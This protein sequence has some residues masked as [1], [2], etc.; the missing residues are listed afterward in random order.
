MAPVPSYSSLRVIIPVYRMDTIFSHPVWSLSVALEALLLIRA[1]RTGLLR[2]F[3]LFYSYIL[4]VLVVDLISTPVYMH[5]PSVYGSF[6]WST[7]LLVAIISYGVLIEIYNQSL[8][9]YD[10]VARFFKVLL[11]IIFCVASTRVAITSL[12][13]SGKGFARAVA[14]LEGDVRQIQVLLLCCLLI[15]FVYYK[16]SIARNLRGLIL[17]Y[18]LFLSTDSISSAFIAHPANGLAPLMRK[19]EPAFYALS[20]VIWVTSL[21]VSHTESNSERSRELEQDYEY[22]ASATRTMLLRA[23]T[24][25]VRASRL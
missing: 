4:C 16:V 13:D 19:V 25:L 1:A 2:N 21:W 8:Q 22:F 17:G 7:E 15:L 9:N 14:D 20:L 11:F 10:G 5:Y 18:G 12:A 6:Y 23:R 24:H 3:P